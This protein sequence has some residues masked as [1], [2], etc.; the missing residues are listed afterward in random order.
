MYVYVNIYMDIC[1]Y[2]WYICIYI[3]KYNYDV[4]MEEDFIKKVRDI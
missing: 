1:G 4:D 2:I 3:Y